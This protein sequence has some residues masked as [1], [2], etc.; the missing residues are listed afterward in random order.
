MTG[1]RTR[2]SSCH[3][4]PLCKPDDLAAGLLRALTK[5]NNTFTPSPSVFQAQTR[6][7]AL[8]LAPLSNKELF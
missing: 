8:A 2:R 7:P 3:N 4:L 1:P 6:T 5:E